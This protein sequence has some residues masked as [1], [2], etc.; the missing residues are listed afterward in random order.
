MGQSS[1]SA[2][3]EDPAFQARKNSIFQKVGRNV[4]NLQRLERRFK[5]LQSLQVNAPAKAIQH[6]LEARKHF[7]AKQTLGPLTQQTVDSFFPTEH[8]QSQFDNLITVLWFTFSIQVEEGQRESLRS[9]LREVVAERNDLIH[10]MFGGFDPGSEESCAA[11]EAKL[12][13]QSAHITEVFRWAQEISDAVLEH[14]AEL[15]TKYP[16][17]NGK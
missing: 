3:I 11:L 10:H 15:A 12:D 2:L 1:E 13:A 14:V 8:P 9:Q 7:L 4:V 5:E 16:S 17:P 6:A